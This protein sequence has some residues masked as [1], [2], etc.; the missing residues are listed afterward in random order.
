M[1]KFDPEHQE[2]IMRLLKQGGANSGDKQRIFDL[3]KLYIDPTHLNWVD[4]GCSSCSS[5]IQ[6]MWSSVKEYIL[7]NGDKFIKIE[8]KNEKNK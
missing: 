2:F 4:S 7:N 3:Y 8:T 6:R 1:E 5:S